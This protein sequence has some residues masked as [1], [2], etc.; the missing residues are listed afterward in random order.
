M[1]K[2]LTRSAMFY[3]I[4][5]I[6][7]LVCAVGAFFYGVQYGSEQ[8]KTSY[9]MKQLNSEAKSKSTPYQQQDL[10]SYYH[11]VFLPYREFQNEWFSALK[12]LEQDDSADGNAIFKDL[13]K[14][15]KKKAGEVAS[16]NMQQSPLLGEA[17]ASVIKSLELFEQT[18]NKA[19]NKA[20]TL[21]SAKLVAAVNDDSIYQAAV[22]QTLSSQQSYY[23]AMMKWAAT[24]NSDIPNEYKFPNILEISK[25]NKLPLIVKNKL[26][27]DH[28]LSH[29]QLT[30]YYPQD[31]VIR[32]DEFIKTGQASKMKIRSIA[33]IAELL[34]N[35]AAVRSGD[36]SNGSEQM[37]SKEVLPLLP[38]FTTNAS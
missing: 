3:S 27:A 7:M 6:F 26:M 31:L 22:K 14:L 37:Y 15:A 25:W 4:G 12:K 34:M 33:A 35:T 30:N 36:Y 9:E 11:T 38:F 28:L 32:I 16:F 1:E 20:K 10:V 21:N 8:T 13:S 23:S 18:S 17:Q 2:Q 29:K 5:F 19:A 24:V